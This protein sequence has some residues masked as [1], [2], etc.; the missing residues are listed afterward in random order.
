[1]SRAYIVPSAGG[2]P[3]VIAPEPPAAAHPVWTPDS[4]AVLI[5]APADMSRGLQGIAIWVAPVDGGAARQAIPASRFREWKIDGQ[6]ANSKLFYLSGFPVGVSRNYGLVIPTPIERHT[7]LGEFPL[8]PQ[9]WTSNGA[10]G[11]FTT[12]PVLEGFPAFGA[13]GAVY[14]EEILFK[15]SLWE[16]PLDY[17][18]PVRELLTCPRGFLHAAL[19]R[20]GNKM[21]FTILQKSG[22]YSLTIKDLPSGQETALAPDGADFKAALTADGKQALYSELSVESLNRPRRLY[23]TNIGAGPREVVCEACPALSD[24][25]ADG[26]YVLSTDCKPRQVVLVDL[27]TGSQTQFAAASHVDRDYA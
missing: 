9:T 13:D 24:V 4:S 21:L 27:R 16:S 19:S 2:A 7:Q 17:S 5:P 8:S 23:R 6:P 20:D 11:Q 18:A 15:V 3:R 25:S 10:P 22:T 12:L 26:R 1:L 14:F